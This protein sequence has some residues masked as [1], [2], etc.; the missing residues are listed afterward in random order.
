V[1]IYLDEKRDGRDAISLEIGA[2]VDVEWL[3]SLTALDQVLADP[4]QPVEAVVVGQMIDFEASLESAE[5]LSNSHPDIGVILLADHVEAQDLRRAIRAGV[6]DVLDGRR[7]SGEL[8]GAIDR[9]RARYGQ[10]HSQPPDGAGGRVVL[11]FSTKGGCGTSVVAANLSI[12]LAERVGVDVGLVDLS[13]TS[14]DLSMMFQLLPAWSV[15]DAAAQGS[16]LDHVA[17]QGYLTKHES[18]VQLLAA[19]TDPALAEQ[20]SPDSVRHL[21]SQMRSLFPVT[22]VDTPSYF[23][24]HFLAALD[25]ADEIVV[26]GSLD[27]PAVKNLKLALQTLEALRFGR[28]RV[29]IVLMRSDSSVGLRVREIEASLG[30]DIDVQIPSSRDVPLSVNE[31]TPLFLSRRRSPVVTAIARLADNVGEHLPASGNDESKRR[32]RLP[33][34]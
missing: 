29:Q 32:R 18:G 16:R 33:W 11:V 13:L 14:G 30:T 5:R 4:S 2:D 6:L 31:G 23:S 10:L 28:D 19:P 34:R 3:P 22:I 1:I 9:S 20:I 26:V 17:L 21:L 7:A 15:Y 24:E 8:R 25:A 12:A 27:V